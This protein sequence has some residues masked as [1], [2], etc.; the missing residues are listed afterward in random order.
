MKWS[1]HCK[2]KHV[3]TRRY[4]A[5][6]EDSSGYK[7]S[8]YCVAIALLQLQLIMLKIASESLQFFRLH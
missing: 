6:I 5:I 7:V 2:I 1:E 4:L 8:Q 3:S